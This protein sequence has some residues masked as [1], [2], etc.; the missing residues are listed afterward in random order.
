MTETTEYRPAPKEEPFIF[1][2]F[3][4]WLK[5]LVNA[6]GKTNSTGPR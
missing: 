1:E 2:E 4:E 6:L 3:I 5:R